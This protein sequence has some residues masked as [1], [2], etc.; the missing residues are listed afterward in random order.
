[1][2]ASK[3]LHIDYGIESYFVPEGEGK[4]LERARNGELEVII[5][6][7]LNGKCSY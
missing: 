1:M 4:D 2:L 3:T 6:L 5:A 7:D